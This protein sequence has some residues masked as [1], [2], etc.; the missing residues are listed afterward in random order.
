MQT[1]MTITQ[2]CDHYGVTA[3]TLRFYEAKE[4]LFPI[5]QGTKRLFTRRCRARLTLILRGKRMGFSLED[6]RNLLN[7][8]DRDGNHQAQRV[9]AIRIGQMRL[10]EMK[11]QQTALASSIIELE[12]FMAGEDAALPKVAA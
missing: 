4:M 1:T 10:V 7:L 6:I 9:E 12:E 11:A 8:Y 2:M 5:R 3:R